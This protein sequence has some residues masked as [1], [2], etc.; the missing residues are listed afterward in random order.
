MH[1]LS[2]AEALIE[3]AVAAATREGAGRIASVSLVVGQ[4]SGVDPDAF[5]FA[6]PVAA[7]GTIAEGA[8]LR[9]REVP[10]SVRCRNCGA[11]SSPDPM[12]CECL[13]C[14][15]KAVD[16]AAGRELILESLEIRPLKA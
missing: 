15:S 13:A 3:Q 9:I 12:L 1:E 4:L 8:E 7:E 2:L 16:V 11:V 5:E 6:F 10:V 14:G